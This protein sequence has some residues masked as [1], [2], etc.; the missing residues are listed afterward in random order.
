MLLH[1]DKCFKG[2]ST[3]HGVYYL[4]RWEIPS[5]TT[6]KTW[7]E[8]KEKER[9]ER[10]KQRRRK[11]KRRRG[12]EEK[13]EGKNRR[14]G[15]GASRVLWPLRDAPL[16][17]LFLLF[18]WPAPPGAQARRKEEKGRGEGLCALAAASR[19]GEAPL[20][21]DSTRIKLAVVLPRGTRPIFC[22]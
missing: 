10:K 20:G 2:S 12:R 5:G 4:T 21:P 16:P 17:S 19:P 22:E 6:V 1:G 3:V 8:K 18:V 9:E 11:G 14:E 7:E 15:R 13:K